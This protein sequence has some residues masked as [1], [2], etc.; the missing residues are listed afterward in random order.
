[1]ET[2]LDKNRLEY[3][4]ANLKDEVLNGEFDEIYKNAPLPKEAVCGFGS[5]RG[6]F[7]QKYVNF[8]TCSCANV[9]T[10]NVS[11][12]QIK[13]VLFSCSALSA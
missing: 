8:L 7:L 2:L 13:S 5:F 4:I 9:Q 3:Y 6:R 10:I 11:D 1:M 12:V